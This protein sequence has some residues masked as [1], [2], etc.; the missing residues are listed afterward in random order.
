MTRH[1]HLKAFEECIVRFHLIKKDLL[2]IN[3]NIDAPNYREQRDYA[4]TAYLQTL[5]EII[6]RGKKY[7]SLN[8]ET[9][10]AIRVA[11]DLD[12]FQRMLDCF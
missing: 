11:I 2:N 12:K 9:D 6:I 4:E 8:P 10:K 3:S 5:D 1:Q 7:L